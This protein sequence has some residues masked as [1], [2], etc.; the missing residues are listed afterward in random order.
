MTGKIG[1]ILGNFSMQ[2]NDTGSY[3]IMV[4][5]L[6]YKD[7]SKNFIV[8]VSKTFIEIRMEENQHLLAAVSVTATKPL[9][10]RKAD[11]YILNVGESVLAKGRNTFDIMNYAPGVMTIGDAIAINGN[12]ATKIMVNGRLLHLSTDQIHNYLAN[13]P[14]DEVESIEIIPVPGAEFSAEGGGGIINIIL[15]K[16]TTEGLTGSVGAGVT[17]PKWLSYNTNEELNYYV[18]GLQLY[19]SHNFD[20]HNNYGDYSEI[21]SSGNET[22]QSVSN[23]TS[24]HQ[25]NNY[26]FGI[27]YNFN[28]KQFLGIEFNG[29][30]NQSSDHTVT[31]S[32]L[33][34]NQDSQ[35]NINTVVPNKSRNSL[36]DI[37]LNYNWTTD[38]LG[39]TFKLTSDY[40]WA[41][42]NQSE[43]FSSRYNDADGKFLFDSVYRNQVPITIKNYDI[44]ANYNK[45]WLHAGTLTFGAKYTH[46]E[47]LNDI[48]YQNLQNGVYVNDTTRSNV[49][50]YT[51][52][53]GAV[54]AQYA[55]NWKNT[56]LQI[57]LR[58]E[59]TH[60][61]GI[62]STTNTSFERNYFNLFPSAFISQNLSAN[63]TLSFSY[64]RR[65]GRPSFDVLNPFEL[66]TDDYTYV[67]GNPDIQ[68]EYTHDME[69][70]YLF[71]NTYELTLFSQLTSHPFGQP[72]TNG[73]GKSIVSEY[74]W[75][76]M[77]Y[78]N[79]YG[80]NLY[81]PV[82]VTKWWTM[83]NNLLV[84][85]D[86]IGYAQGKNVMTIFQGKSTQDITIMKSWRL[87][88]SGFYQSSYN[89]E[90][91]VYVPQYNIDAGLRKSFLHDKLEA[92]FL[93]TDIFNTLRV[94]YHSLNSSIMLYEKQKNLTRKLFLQLTYNFS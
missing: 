62:S 76:N 84:Y 45:I 82:T 34:E 42:Y 77:K 2:A 38:S 30:N 10:T 90:N 48:Q 71:K 59:Q 20:H 75:Q 39:S 3:R 50:D 6:G 94:D 27:G 36:Y 43:N 23:Y 9:I 67:Q 26:R 32:V 52:N 37:S 69:L 51:E 25:S 66:R 80:V 93:V 28:K 31:Q 91:L 60:T 4:S 54:F 44:E 63:N 79:N 35:R 40:T 92:S 68:P 83:V 57:G 55:K 1:D 19:A 24:S 49:F 70:S 81:V 65:I 16:N 14:A 61:L 64:S 13:L 74:L 33:N 5:A 12:T 87:E 72:L 22:Y 41:N 18:N 89:L 47:T 58:G 88:L 46:T 86:A 78:D 85:H 8:S 11:R 29:N 56:S 15:K 53:V 21:A 17:T 7:T 73:G